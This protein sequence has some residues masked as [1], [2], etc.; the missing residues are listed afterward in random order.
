MNVISNTNKI[1]FAASKT[2]TT[3][4]FAFQNMAPLPLVIA[5]SRQLYEETGLS[6]SAY[7]GLFVEEGSVGQ[8]TVT[9]YLTP[10]LFHRIIT[11][12]MGFGYADTGSG[13]AKVKTYNAA[14]TTGKPTIPS[15]T[16]ARTIAMFFDD[17]TTGGT[18]RCDA[19]IFSASITGSN[20]EGML[21]VSM[22]VGISNPVTTSITFPSSFDEVTPNHRYAAAATTMTFGASAPA[23]AD[24]DTW[25]ITFNTG[26]SALKKKINNSFR[27]EGGARSIMITIGSTF[28][29]ALRDLWRNS[30]PTFG[31]IAI[32]MNNPV[33][34]HP[35]LVATIANCVLG[36]RGVD[37][38]ISGVQTENTTWTSAPLSASFAVNGFSDANS[39]IV[40]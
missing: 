16:V 26:I 30:N 29:T 35:S 3:P 17:G 32:S 14:A 23:Q 37:A 10:S 38:P 27:A 8:I 39:P 28:S 18:V 21:Q 1:G 25:S 11:E 7:A 6:T 2:A 40:T 22:T 5:P 13:N 31:S 33:T 15:Y 36:D 12:L 34:A 24:V 20:A 19:V 4:T 9:S